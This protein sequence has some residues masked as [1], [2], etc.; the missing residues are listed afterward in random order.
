[1]WEGI[2]TKFSTLAPLLGTDG[3]TAMIAEGSKISYFTVIALIFIAFM[4]RIVRR[5]YKFFF[6]SLVRG[7]PFR[8][9][10]AFD[11][12]FERRQIVASK[13]CPH[14]AEPL[15]LSAVLCDACDYNFL[16]EMVG[17]GQKLLPS[18]EP[19]AHEAMEQRYAHS[20]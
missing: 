14:C 17:T 19:L 5:S 7:R 13:K 10:R 6:G 12:M 9:E 3:I 1:M 4:A 20:A 16:S 8:K 11:R 18:P 15:P 2:T